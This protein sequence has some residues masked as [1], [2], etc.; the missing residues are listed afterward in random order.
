MDNI[1]RFMQGYGYSK[2]WQRWRNYYESRNNTAH[3]YNLVK[4]RSLIKLV[5]DLLEDTEYLIN[6]LK[7]S[8]DD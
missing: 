6:T 7:E 3:E 4:A 5:P 1:F 8:N 2:D